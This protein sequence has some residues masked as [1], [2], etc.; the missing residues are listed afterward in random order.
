M[1]RGAFLHTPARFMRRVRARAE[2]ALP[3]GLREIETNATFS[4]VAYL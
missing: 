3:F 2:T 4:R 1:A